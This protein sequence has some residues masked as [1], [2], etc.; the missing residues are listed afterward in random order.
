MGLL[1]KLFK[2]NKD[3]EEMKNVAQGAE[4]RKR[5]IRNWGMT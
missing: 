1:D 3:A 5:C 4:Q 2:K